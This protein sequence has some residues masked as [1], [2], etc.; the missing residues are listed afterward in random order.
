MKSNSVPVNP[1]PFYMETTRSLHLPTVV[2]PELSRFIH[3]LADHFNVEYGFAIMGDKVQSQPATRSSIWKHPLYFHVVI[4]IFCLQK[5]DFL[6]FR[7]RAIYPRKAVMRFPVNSKWP[8]G[9]TRNGGSSKKEC[10]NTSNDV[11]FHVCCAASKPF[12]LSKSRA[13]FA[14]HSRSI[15]HACPRVSPV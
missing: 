11:F 15:Y 10:K 7:L 9:S 13:P 8:T 1:A 14:R 6:R 12:E 2:R 4:I 5:G 3:I